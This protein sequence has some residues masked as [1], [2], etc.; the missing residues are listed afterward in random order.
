MGISKNSFIISLI[1]S[2]LSEE[3]RSLSDFF[4]EKGRDEFLEML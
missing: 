4:G 1:P 3:V 2:L